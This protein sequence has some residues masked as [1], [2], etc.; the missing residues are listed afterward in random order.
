MKLDICNTL[1]CGQH[2][3]CNTGT[4][5]CDCDA[6]YQGPSCDG[7]YFKLKL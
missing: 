2:G 3:T 5:A 1:S 7:K 4:K 6:G